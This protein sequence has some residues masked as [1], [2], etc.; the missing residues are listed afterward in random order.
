MDIVVTDNP[1]ASRY[2]GR[3]GDDLVGFVDYRPTAEALVFVH[4]ETDPTVRG[5]GLG[6]VLV[7]GAL[8]DVRRRGTKVVPNCPFVAEVIDRNPEYADLLAG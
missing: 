1:A 6:T 3:A 8:D 7:R 4:A 2:E 5:R